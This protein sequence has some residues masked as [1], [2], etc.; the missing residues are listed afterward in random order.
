MRLGLATS[1][2]VLVV[3]SAPARAQ[4]A[5]PPAEP[6]GKETTRVADTTEAPAATTS[7][8]SWATTAQLAR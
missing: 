1:L 4:E 8:A 7:V 5:A 2:L 3:S 6:E